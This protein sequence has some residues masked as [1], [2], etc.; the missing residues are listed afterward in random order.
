MCRLSA[1]LR[2]SRHS[3]LVKWEQSP[4]DLASYAQHHSQPQHASSRIPQHMHQHAPPSPSSQT[5]TGRRSG[6]QLTFRGGLAAALDQQ[7]QHQQPLPVDPCML[8]RDQA[9]AEELV[10]DDV[11]PVHPQA[12]ALSPERLLLMAE[13]LYALRPMV[14]VILLHLS[15][16]EAPAPDTLLHRLRGA[17]AFLV[18][19]ALDLASIQLSSQALLAAR[20]GAPDEMQRPH[21]FDEEL[22]RRRMLLYLYLLRSPLFDRAT[23]PAMRRMAQ[24][25]KGVPLGGTM[26]QYGLD[27]LRFVHSVHFYH[28]NS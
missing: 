1:L 27:M 10:A 18:S 3:M 2:C 24:L 23:L 9:D 22:A 7:Q 15:D 13:L 21:P 17:L 5:Q 16:G 26:A 19:L 14:Y 6:L 4:L 25:L 11:Q 20:G 8:I 12:Q 28:S